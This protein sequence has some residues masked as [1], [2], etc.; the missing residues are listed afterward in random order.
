MDRR[1]GTRCAAICCNFARVSDQMK[2]VGSFSAMRSSRAGKLAG[3]W[4]PHGEVT[5]VVVVDVEVVV[6]TA[7]TVW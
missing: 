5:A 1:G 6:V 3:R 4:A 7:A 2:Y